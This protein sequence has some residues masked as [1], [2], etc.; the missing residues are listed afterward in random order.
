MIA[1]FEQLRLKEIEIGQSLNWLM[2][3]ISSWFRKDFTDDGNNANL[4]YGHW[5]I[6]R[7]EDKELY[8][9]VKTLASDKLKHLSILL[10]TIQ[11]LFFMMLRNQHLPLNISKI[12]HKHLQF[13]LMEKSTLM[14]T[15]TATRSIEKQNNLTLR[16]DTTLFECRVLKQMKLKI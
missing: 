6:K 12:H 11:T 1:L 4:Q 13:I 16:A 10:P 9:L 14:Q 3:L 8:A 7:V 5:N 2:I 15:I